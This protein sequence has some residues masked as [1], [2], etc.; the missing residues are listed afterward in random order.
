MS[1]R[2][3]SGYNRDQQTLV[4]QPHTKKALRAH[5]RVSRFDQIKEFL[6][7]YEKTV[8]IKRTETKES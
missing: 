7:S 6:A 1:N 5:Q 3:K 2:R 4:N 8:G